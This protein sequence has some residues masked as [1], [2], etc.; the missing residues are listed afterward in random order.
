MKISIITVVYN[1]AITIKDSIDSVISQTYPDIEYIIVDG[2]SKDNTLDIVRSYG[3]KIAKVVSEKDKGIYDA[4]NK[5]IGL[6]TG[7]VVAILNSDDFYANN[8]VI[9]DVMKE[10]QKDSSV[11]CVYGDLEYVDQHDTTKIKRVW[12]SRP[13]RAGLFR[14][15]WHPAHPSFFVKK[16]VYNAYGVFRLDLPIAADYELMLRFLHVHKIKSVYIPGFMVKMREGGTSNKSIKNIYKANLEVL[17]SWRV[18][19]RFVPYWIFVTKPL[20]KVMQMR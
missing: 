6:A 18:N 17:K 10:F 1:G 15:G 13:Y 16:S 4:M 8:H 20:S 7:D 12:K 3:D 2:L 14:T 5:G 9:A 19:H 11:E